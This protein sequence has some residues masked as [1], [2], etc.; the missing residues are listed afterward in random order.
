MEKQD[1]E[2]T[3]G[4][5]QKATHGCAVP[6]TMTIGDRVKATFNLVYVIKF[7]TNDVT[8]KLLDTD[9]SFEFADDADTKEKRNHS[10][11]IK[12]R[13]QTIIRKAESIPELKDLVVEEYKARVA[14]RASLTRR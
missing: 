7:I 5:L 10:Q 9:L 13:I 8:S 12:R 11:R 3:Y 6:I 4:T 2:I 14:T 1:I